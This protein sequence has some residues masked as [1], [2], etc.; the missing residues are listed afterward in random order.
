MKKYVLLFLL[1]FIIIGLNSCRKLREELLAPPEEVQIPEG[2][3]VAICVVGDVT[4]KYVYKND[5][6]YQYFIDDMEQ[7]EDTLDSIQEQAFL[8]N[9]SVQNYLEDEYGSTGCVIDVYIYP[10]ND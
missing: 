3:L 4:N 8:H 2:S 5:G 7:S 10:D 6:V 9:E 1:S